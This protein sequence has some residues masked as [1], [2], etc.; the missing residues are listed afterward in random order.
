MRTIAR[1]F[2]ATVVL[3]VAAGPALAA[4]MIVSAGP[5][6]A[7]P[8]SHN[9]GG[10]SLGKILSLAAV[11]GM[12]IRIKDTGLL[13]K[14]F[15]TRAAASASDYK[16]GV[17]QSGQDWAT[18]T[19]AA[20]DNYSAGVQQAIAD[21]RFAKGVAAAGP[22][23]FVQR[24]STLG[25]QRYPT[26]VGAAEGDWARGVQ[27]SLDVLKNLNLPPRRPKGDPGNQARAN[28]VAAALRANKVGK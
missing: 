4:P 13:A 9:S 23:K 22:Q 10:S 19:A 8:A 24:A 3:A 7:A 6:I 18:N 16:S 1:I 20:G 28:A 12:G 15:V 14:K 26:G 11:A 17:E 25:A 2:L 27:S 5:T 21:G